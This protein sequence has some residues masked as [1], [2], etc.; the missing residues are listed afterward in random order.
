MLGRVGSLQAGYVSQ[1][2][3]SAFKPAGSSNMM[4]ARWDEYDFYVQDTW[5]ARPNLV[6]DYGL[7]DDARLAPKFQGFPSLVPNQDMRME[8]RL[9]RP[10]SLCPASS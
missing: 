4:D 1:P 2:S 3:L 8:R 10:C 7:R 9:P 6:I 5:H